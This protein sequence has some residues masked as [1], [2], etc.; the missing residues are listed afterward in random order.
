M[1]VSHWLEP[2]MEWVTRMDMD[3]E[4]IWGGYGYFFVKSFGVEWVMG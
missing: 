1:N 4:W 3:M 2:F